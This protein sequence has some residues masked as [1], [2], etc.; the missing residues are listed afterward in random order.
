MVKDN[1]ALIVHLLPKTPKSLVTSHRATA[2]TNCRPSEMQPTAPENQKQGHHH[3]PAMIPLI[4]S[5]PIP[6]S[7][8]SQR[9]HLQNRRGRRRPYDGKGLTTV[10]SDAG[11]AGNGVDQSE[12]LVNFF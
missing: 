12:R 10:V 2:P 5:S 6:P 3:A 4:S 11:D 1:N 8:P 7:Q 9:S